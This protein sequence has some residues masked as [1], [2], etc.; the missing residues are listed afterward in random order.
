M[1]LKEMLKRHEGYSSY[2]YKC[3]AGKTT[4]G[5][6]H[7]IDAN[8]LPKD[9]EV[10]L[11]AKGTISP[12]MAERLL[13]YDIETAIRDC[14]D[15]Y[16]AFLTFTQNRQDAL[17][18]FL[19]NVGRKTA[20]TFKNTNKAINEGRWADAASEFESSLWYV[21]VGNRSKEIVAMIKEG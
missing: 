3:P 8:P 14:K 15:L 4:I 17:A 10:Y 1:S 21:Q 16:N 11:S 2:A 13:D 20:R 12:E 18:D 6:G 9:I 19:F 5:W 7:N